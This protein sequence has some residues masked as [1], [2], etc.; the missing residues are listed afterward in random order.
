MDT[1]NVNGCFGAEADGAIG[2]LD[3]PNPW[4]LKDDKPTGRVRS[5]GVLPGTW[6]AI[7]SLSDPTTRSVVPSPLTIPGTLLDSAANP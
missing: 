7:F 1:P 2:V 6:C 5:L 4:F 3:S